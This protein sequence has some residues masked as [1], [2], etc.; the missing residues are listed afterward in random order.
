MTYE[1]LSH[2]ILVVYVISDVSTSLPKRAELR[3]C[4]LMIYAK[5]TTCLYG[6][7]CETMNHEDFDVEHL[8]F[9]ASLS[10]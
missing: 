1:V 4:L 5:K 2:D 7:E 6:T 3:H 9:Q 10:Y 8:K